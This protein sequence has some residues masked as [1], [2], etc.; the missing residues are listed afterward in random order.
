MFAD[1]L[2]RARCKEDSV[3][4]DLDLSMLDRKTKSL[5]GKSPKGQ[6]SLLIRAELLYSL[7]FV[8]AFQLAVVNDTIAESGKGD[9]LGLAGL[10][11]RLAVVDGLD[12]ELDDIFG[13]HSL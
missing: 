2:G 9:P 11:D 3:G 5:L 4:E 10:A 13:G 12:S 6:V 8:L 7:G 1:F